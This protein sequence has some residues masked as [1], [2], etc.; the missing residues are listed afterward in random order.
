MGWGVLDQ[1]VSSLTN[2]AVSFLLAHT[3]APAQFGAF[4][5]TYITY[6]IAL[7]TSRG[8]STD[9]LLVRYSGVEVSRWRRATGMAA[10]TA[11]V[12]GLIAG[13][14]SLVAAFIMG[15]TTGEGFLALGLTLP[16]LMLQ[17]SW[18]Y[19]FFAMGRGPHAFLNDT[20]WAVFLLLGLAIMHVTGHTDVFW[21]VLAWGSSACVAAAFGPLQ[22]GVMPKVLHAWA[23]VHIQ[24]DLGPRYLLEGVVYNGAVQ[25]RA[26]ATSGLLGLAVLGYLA[27]SV[28][29]FGPI[30]ILSMAMGLVI[31][32]EAARIMRRAPERLALF[33]A[34]VSTA[35][36]VITLL[37]GLTLLVGMPRGLGHILL[38]S[39]WHPTYPLVLPSVV[40]AVAGTAGMGTGAVLHALGAARKTL[41]LALF[42]MVTLVS[43]SVAGA[44]LLGAPGVVWGT[45]VAMWIATIVS[46]WQLHVALREA[47]LPQTS[48]WGI[49]ASLFRGRGLAT[50]EAA[51]AAIRSTTAA[52]PSSRQSAE[53]ATPRN[54]KHRSGL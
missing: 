16:G 25:V 18:R 38:G 9:P 40:S 19:C 10:G 3:L 39:I 29:I 12:V 36:S 41:R 15:G 46:W 45:A 24:R 4:S 52:A 1:A 22:A 32:P 47:N 50:P 6:G 30:N 21:A 5:L 11:V 26:Y 37:W 35:M 43:L 34:A 49:I 42:N 17:D 28:T 33:C 14:L 44:E 2:F 7:N 8:L 53:R 48:L 13:S 27:A 54:G 31:I 51:N 20:I 23:W